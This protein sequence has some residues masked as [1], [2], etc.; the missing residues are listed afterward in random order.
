MTRKFAVGAELAPNAELLAIATVMRLHSGA[1]V[2][3]G[4]GGVGKR[5]QPNRA[6]AI[7]G[8]TKRGKV[9]TFAQP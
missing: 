9:L 4:P 3:C 6:A 5:S 1:Y 7:Q 8:L 2:L